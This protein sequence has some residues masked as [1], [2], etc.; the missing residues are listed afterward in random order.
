MTGQ[1]LLTT[2]FQ[3]IGAYAA[4]ET[5]TASDAQDGLRRL[6]NL[7]SGWRTQYGT[8][9]AI[10]RWVFPLTANQQTYTIGNGGDFNVP[11][12]VMVTG[13]GLLLN[14]LASAQSVTSITRSGYAATVT[15]TSHGFAVGDETV[16]AGAT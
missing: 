1:T 2:C 6:N 15:L 10:E 3:D 16:I 12:P 8:V 4:G 11:R 5:L 14:G 13:A 9:T 7:I